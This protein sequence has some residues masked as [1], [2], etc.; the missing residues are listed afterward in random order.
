MSGPTTHKKTEFRCQKC[1]KLLAM[2]E[3]GNFEVK[4]LR[5]G[6]LNYFFEHMNEQV[7]ITDP[8]GVILY[9]NGVVEKI[10]GYSVDEIIG[11]RPSLWGNQMPREF[12]RVMWHTIKV[13]KREVKVT[14]RNKRKDGTFYNADLRISPVLDTRGNVRFFVG[15]EGIT[16]Q[17]INLQK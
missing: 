12:Y 3:H 4:C 14:L 6:T 2:R 7:I 8:D 9:T 1:K 16:Q 13:E 11:K 5:C 10:T 17:V 15:I